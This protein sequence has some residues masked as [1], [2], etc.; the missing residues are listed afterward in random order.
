MIDLYQL[1]ARRAQ[2]LKRVANMIAVGIVGTGRARDH[3]GHCPHGSASHGGADKGAARQ[4]GFAT[5]AEQ[6]GHASNNR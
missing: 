3:G 5:N 1:T 2:I 4:H 6:S